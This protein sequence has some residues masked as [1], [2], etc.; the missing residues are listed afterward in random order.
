MLNVER[1]NLSWTSQEGWG[2]GE[3]DLLL[4]YQGLALSFPRVTHPHCMH[5]AYP[6]V[7][8]RASRCPGETVHS[9]IRACMALTHL[10]LDLG[11]LVDTFVQSDLQYVH[12]SK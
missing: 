12:L 9:S 2:L 6:S 1:Y 4:L 10:H 7:A 3:M 8:S 5:G 11:H